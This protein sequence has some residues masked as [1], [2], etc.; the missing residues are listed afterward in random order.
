[1]KRQAFQTTLWICLKKTEHLGVLQISVFLKLCSAL[2]NDFKKVPIDQLLPVEIRYNITALGYLRLELQINNILNNDKNTVPKLN[3]RWGVKIVFYYPGSNGR[4][5]IVWVWYA[6]SF[7]KTCSV[8]TTLWPSTW[9]WPLR[10]WGVSQIHL[11]SNS[12]SVNGTLK[13]RHLKLLGCIY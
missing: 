4:G 8:L 2:H 9:W 13:R 1:M 12:Y 3:A 6:Y 5:H 11:V 10:R 7:D